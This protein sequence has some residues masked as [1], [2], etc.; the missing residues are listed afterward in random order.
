[1][2]TDKELALFAESQVPD[3]ALDPA[4]DQLSRRTLLTRIG[5]GAAGTLAASLGAETM[6]DA[7]P[8]PET[9][10]SDITFESK[11]DDAAAQVKA[12]LASPKTTHKRGGVIVVHEIFGLSDHIKSVAVRLAEAGYDALAVDFFS[13]AGPLPDV[14]GDFK[15]LMEYVTKIADSQILQDAAGAA[16]YLRS[17]SHSNGKVGIV[18]FCWGGR[19]SM[20]YDAAAPDLNAAVAY[21]GRISGEKTANQT[22]YPIDVADKMNAPLLGNFGAEDKGIPPSEVEKLSAALKA[23]HKTAELYEYE[24]AGHAF[25]NDTRESYRPDAAK[26]AWKR[27]LDWYKKYLG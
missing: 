13:N 14:K 9:M 18:G 22:Q 12:F 20:L 21:Y 5:A 10:R 17:L 24:K 4:L 1:M 7:E 3:P 26:L 25:N 6:A 16:K 15:P 8:K 27:T 23:A 2:L 19:I 11:H